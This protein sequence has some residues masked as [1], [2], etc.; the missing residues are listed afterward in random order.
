MFQRLDLDTQLRHLT[1][2][3]LHRLDLALIYHAVCMNFSLHILKQCIKPLINFI[4]GINLS[5]LFLDN[6]A[7]SVC[8]QLIVL[9]K[10]LLFPRQRKQSH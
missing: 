9:E 1:D 2:Q 4:Q 6:C 8:I 5:A 10:L 7:E 3:L